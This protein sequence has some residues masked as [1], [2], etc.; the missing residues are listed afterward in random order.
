MNDYTL[1]I[2]ARIDYKLCLLVHKA[3]VGHA[4]QYIKDLITPVADLHHEPRCGQ[5][6]VAT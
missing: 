4:P 2:V 5:L 3:L 6:I 1:P